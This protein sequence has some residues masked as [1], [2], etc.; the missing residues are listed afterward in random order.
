MVV[1]CGEGLVGSVQGGERGLD[2]LEVL[3]AE[4][5]ERGEGVADAE[6]GGGVVPDFEVG[7]A[8]CD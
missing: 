5:G 4:G 3:G 7:G 8:L 1:V 6:Q 2:G